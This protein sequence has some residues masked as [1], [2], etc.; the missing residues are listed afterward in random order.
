MLQ[1]IDDHTL[2]RRIQD[3]LVNYVT[4]HDAYAVVETAGGVLSPAPSG[5]TQADF[6]RPLRLPVVL[7]GD[8]RLGGIGSTIS[9]W[10]SLHVR[11]YDVPSI[12]LFE[13]SI[14]GNS[15]YLRDYFRE[16]NIPTLSLPPPPAVNADAEQD[17]AD[18]K[19]YYDKAHQHESLDA[20]ID[21]FEKYHAQRLAK[22]KSLSQR[23]NDIIWHPFMQHTER[24]E[25]T[26]LAI[27]SA[28]GDYFQAHTS[29]ASA[30]SDREDSLVKPAFD[31]SAS[32][33][34]QGLGHGNPSLALTAAHTA[35][36]YG[37]VMFA[38]AAHEPAVTLAETLLKNLKNPRLSRVFY[39]D[40]GSTG[41]EVALKMAL[42]ASSKRYGWKT[43]TQVEILG[44]TGSYHGDT[45]GTMD[46][47]EPNVYNEKVEWYQGK[48]HW[49][50]FPTVKMREGKWIIERPESIKDIG[51]STTFDSL[52]R[53]LDF[54]TRS[55]EAKKYRKYLDKSVRKL[56]AEG[57]KFGALIMEPIIL[58]AGGMLF[59]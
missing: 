27:D 46:C 13:D 45:M 3:E 32:W 55:A 29:N 47:S 10:E 4:G 34:T 59:A 40:N 38:N 23:A 5:S 11:G 56:Q 54:N 8:H 18:M 19:A 48:G 37:H 12:L 9:A 15:D 50:D 22:L 1:P 30:A 58:G 44:L 2:L 53:V 20:C 42:K 24:S 39:S 36:R 17:E 49:F 52:D 26:I 41:M 16:R 6:Y 43:G 7:V 33:W 28:Y 25:K 31:G 51:E 35:G 57:R 14:Y 21:G